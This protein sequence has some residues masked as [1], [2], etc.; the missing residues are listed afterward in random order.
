[1]ETAQPRFHK[2][3]HQEGH[4]CWGHVV[5]SSQ[6]DHP[7][8]IWHLELEMS[9]AWRE[10]P[11]YRDGASAPSRAPVAAQPSDCNT[12][13]VGTLLLFV[14]GAW[15]GRRRRAISFSSPSVTAKQQPGLELSLPPCQVSSRQ[16]EKCRQA[17]ATCHSCC[18]SM[19]N[20][21]HSVLS[22]LPRRLLLAHFCFLWRSALH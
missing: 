14:A 6:S 3:E 7:L 19:D 13:A 10:E 5:G 8:G 16:Y 15:G 20:S 4:L 22:P 1:M 11:H 9:E 18:D 12:L 21:R 17:E 2:R